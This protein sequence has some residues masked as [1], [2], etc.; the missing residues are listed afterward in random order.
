MV[1]TIGKFFII[2]SLIFLFIL[3]ICEAVLYGA[4]YIFDCSWVDGVILV[5]EIFIKLFASIYGMYLIYNGRKFVKIWP[6]GI[7][8]LGFSIYF[9]ISAYFDF[10]EIS[11]NFEVVLASA[12]MILG[13]LLLL[14]L[15]WNRRREL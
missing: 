14:G 2:V 3:G 9:I 13:V 11:Y 4:Y 8:L 7:V 12:D 6:F 10:S 1:K 15:Y 5:C